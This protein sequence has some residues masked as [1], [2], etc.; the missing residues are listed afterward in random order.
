MVLDLAGVIEKSRLVE[1]TQ[2]VLC[3]VSGGPD[4]MAL[5][6]AF[7]EHSKKNGYRLYAGHVNH[8]I[9]INACQDEKL[10]HDFCLHLDIPFLS[11]SRD[12][13]NE[14]K[15][16]GK[17]LEEAARDVR[18][19]CLESM[20]Q[21]SDTQ[22]I[23]LAHHKSDQA[24]TVLF[25]LLRGTG[26]K[27][28]CGMQSQNGLLI[29]PFLSITRQEIL[30]YVAFH[31]IPFCEDETNYNQNYS[32]N[33]LRL[34]IMPSLHRINQNVEDSLCRLS[35][36][37][38]EDEDYLEGQARLLL[39]SAKISTSEVNLSV[40]MDAPLPLRRRVLRIWL[41]EFLSKDVSFDHIEG[42]MGILSS[43]GEW[44]LPGGNRVLCSSRRMIFS[45]AGKAIK[46]ASTE[47]LL[48]V[49]GKTFFDGDFIS[50]NWVLEHASCSAQDFIQYFDGDRIPEDT[51]FRHRRNGDIITPLGMDNSK[52][53]KDYL[54][55]RKIP[56]FV[57]DK[58][59]LLCSGNQ[60][61]WV[62]GCGISEQ[63]KITP[64]TKRILCIQYKNI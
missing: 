57:R 28:L 38:R 46:A 26:M 1:G 33:Y 21:R 53:L 34:T 30:E 22:Y 37:V 31:H 2:G 11:M 56:H 52:K 58:L 48:N 16:T 32:R 5:L 20:R 40:L 35:S 44:Y 13:P 42:I 59:T 18:Y 47:V 9:R 39:C 50:S 51:A 63:V 43:G 17:S 54:I 8:C 45:P 49:A 12:V 41:S 64:Y 55:D 23:A 10:V 60:V 14:A 25:R 24:E 6:H 62:V 3:A 36:L 7:N 29:R 15:L 4:S 27:G 19:E 61:L